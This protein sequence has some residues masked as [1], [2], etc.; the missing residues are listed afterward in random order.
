MEWWI[1][2]LSL[3]LRYWDILRKMECNI[4]CTVACVEVIVSWI[5]L[6]VEIL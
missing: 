3:F 6:V 5:F 4:D 1:E 2:L